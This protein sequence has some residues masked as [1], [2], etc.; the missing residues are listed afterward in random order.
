LEIFMQTSRFQLGLIA[1][2]AIGL[3][4]SLSSS[5]AI[6]YPAGG[7]VSL[8]TNPVWSTGGTPIEG[9]VVVATA[10]DGDLV[11]TDFD[12][13]GET[14]S[15]FRVA[16]RLTDGTV[17]ADYAMT[18]AHSN[19]GLHRGYESGIRVP[20]GDSLTLDFDSYYSESSFRYTL[21]GYTAQP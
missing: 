4:F 21:T 9:S 16:L 17:V 6:G 7:A 20:Q 5:D 10:T 13:T 8:G 3:G 15:W 18:D 12:V 2:L 1:T 19:G 14:S 11:I